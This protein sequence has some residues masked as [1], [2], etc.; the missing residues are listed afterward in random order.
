M[1]KKRLEDALQKVNQPVEVVFRSFELDPTMEKEVNMSIHEK[2]AQ[3]YGM[4]IEQ[5]KMNARNVEQMAQTVGLEFRFDKMILTNT[6]D[7]HRLAMFAKEHGKMHE[8]TERLL[9]AYYTE[10]KHI[11]DHAT[12]VELAQEVG[13]D[14]EEV[15]TLLAGDDMSN[16]VRS[17]EKEAAELGITSIPFFLINRKYA[18]TGA[19]SEEA[20]IEAI[21]QITT[22]DG[23]FTNIKDGV[24]CDENGCEIPKK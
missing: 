23:P 19:Q 17:D 2:L 8:M 6:F 9:K 1:G 15:T 10:G 4:S 18:I 7:A 12:L 14:S 11:G 16:L 24:L 22:Q 3:K 20:F 13:F 21:E 5:A